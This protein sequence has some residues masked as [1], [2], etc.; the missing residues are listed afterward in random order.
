M[1][2]YGCRHHELGCDSGGEKPKP[3]HILTHES[4][5]ASDGHRTQSVKLYTDK[6]TRRTWPFRNKCSETYMDLISLNRKP[7]ATRHV[8]ECTT[9]QQYLR[10]FYTIPHLPKSNSSHW[11]ATDHTATLFTPLAIAIQTPSNSNTYSRPQL[12]SKIFG[13]SIRFLIFRWAMF[14]RKT[15]PSTKRQSERF[16]PA[17]FFTYRNEL[18]TQ[19][20][21]V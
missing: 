3:N 19:V 15:T 17:I 11:T 6:Y 8:L 7:T 2:L 5:K 9:E 10:G 4:P 20:L 14:L 13:V 21:L 18:G 1:L 16:P 12:S